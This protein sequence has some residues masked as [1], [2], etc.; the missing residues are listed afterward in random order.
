MC[1]QGR[2]AP[3]EWYEW[4]AA[5]RPRRAGRA[6]RRSDPYLCSMLEGL[7][8]FKITLNNGLPVYA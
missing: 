8:Y 6:V 4:E 3:A 1:A 2:C 7:I 5:G